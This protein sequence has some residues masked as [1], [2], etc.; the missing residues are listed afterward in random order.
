MCYLCF[1]HHSFRYPD[2]S[3]TRKSFSPFIKYSS[4]VVGII[5]KLCND[6]NNQLQNIFITPQKKLHSLCQSLPIPLVP[7]S[8]MPQ[9][10]TNLLFLSLQVC[11]FRT[12]PVNRI[13]QYVVF[14]D[15][16][17]SLQA[18]LTNFVYPFFN[19]QTFGLFPL[20]GYYE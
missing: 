13:M 2:F 15:W 7:F 11:L 6:H 4:V 16:L 20:L 12:W 9:T 18:M 14:C 3:S 1:S 5:T 17:L 19:W 10:G 8:L